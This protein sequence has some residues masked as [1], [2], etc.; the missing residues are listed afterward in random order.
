MQTY[1]QLTTEI[2]KE[3]KNNS[4]ITDIQEHFYYLKM[5]QPERFKRLYFDENG[6]EPYS[7]ELDEIVNELIVSGLI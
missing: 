3:F 5:S 7:S 2:F 6:H 4:I 1:Q